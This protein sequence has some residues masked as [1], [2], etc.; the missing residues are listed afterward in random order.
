M[1]NKSMYSNKIAP[2]R[3]YNWRIQLS[4]CLRMG[5][6]C[7]ALL[8]PDQVA[9]EVR[10]VSES[11]IQSIVGC[12]WAEQCLRSSVNVNDFLYYQEENRKRF[13]RWLDLYR[14][15]TPPPEIYI[16]RKGSVVEKYWKKGPP[17]HYWKPETWSDVEYHIHLP[18]PSD[19]LSALLIE[20]YKKKLKRVYQ[21][22][23]PSA[24]IEYRPLEAVAAPSVQGRHLITTSRTRIRDLTNCEWSEP[25]SGSHLKATTGRD[26][27]VDLNEFLYRHRR[28]GVFGRW[29]ALYDSTEPVR[30][31][32]EDLSW[33]EI[34]AGV[35]AKCEH[36]P[37]YSWKPPEDR[38]VEY[39]ISQPNPK[40]R[41][42]AYLLETTVG[43]LTGAYRIRPGGTEQEFRPLYGD[44]ELP[45]KRYRGRETWRR[46]KSTHH[47]DLVEVR[48]EYFTPEKLRKKYG[49]AWGDDFEEI[50]RTALLR[51]Y[52]LIDPREFFKT[53]DQLRAGDW[54]MPDWDTYRRFTNERSWVTS[55]DEQVYLYCRSD[56]DVVRLLVFA[57]SGGR[58]LTRI[59]EYSARHKMRALSPATH[60][61]MP[62][63]N[64]DI[65]AK[66]GTELE[67]GSLSVGVSSSGLFTSATPIDFFEGHGA[68]FP[69]W[70]AR[71][72]KVKS[73]YAHPPN[74]SWSDEDGRYL[75]FRDKDW[76]D[77]QDAKPEWYVLQYA[78]AEH[79]LLGKLVAIHHFDGTWA[80]RTYVPYVPRGLAEY[81]ME[82]H[83]KG[84][85]ETE[86][87]LATAPWNKASELEKYLIQLIEDEYE[88]TM[89]EEA[90]PLLDIIEYKRKVARKKWEVWEAQ[91]H[92][93]DNPV[94]TEFRPW[95]LLRFPGPQVLARVGGAIAVLI[96]IFV[97]KIH[98]RRAHEREINEAR[99]RH[100]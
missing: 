93:K 30:E 18:N 10:Y 67:W 94:D 21:M 76:E 57:E 54:Y 51:G 13:H 33:W 64:R 32:C 41:F 38:F 62:I 78:K 40:D 1:I 19:P 97:V 72:E 2:Q 82:H 55:R 89:P 23:S 73:T 91:Q 16:P 24:E 88:G 35:K 77:A 11:Q 53:Q 100:I 9:A 17:V 95:K 96:L 71:F 27:I 80:S 66:I 52:R 31:E 42:S 86:T 8:T 59:Y 83:G 70:K 28:G 65:S 45:I 34:L 43:K 74:G 26:T 48:H 44:P 4:T 15:T 81:L 12:K 98:R 36:I 84:L 20:T 22:H 46:K 69:A 50:Q 49:L 68:V 75:M 47:D 56:S 58:D 14:S 61:A 99:Q 5:V 37:A 85:S 79:P 3:Q 6:L 7:A 25:C 39:F 90:Q 63:R 60:Q 87:W 92:A 29:R